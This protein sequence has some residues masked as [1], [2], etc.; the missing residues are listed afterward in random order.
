[1]L[2]EILDF[3]RDSTALVRDEHDPQAL[4]TSALGEV[5]RNHPGS[6]VKINYD[7]HH[8]HMLDCDGARIVRVLTNIL[9][10]AVGAMKRGGEKCEGELWISTEEIGNDKCAHGVP[11]PPPHGGHGAF[12][13]MTDPPGPCLLST[14]RQAR[15]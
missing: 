11:P 8:E 13:G 5:L 10:N 4:I 2:N 7:L 9:D 12:A 14:F 3:S 6:T 1:M 15:I